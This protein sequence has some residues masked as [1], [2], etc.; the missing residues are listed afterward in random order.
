MLAKIRFKYRVAARK[1]RFIIYL[2]RKQARPSEPEVVLQAAGKVDLSAERRSAQTLADLKSFGEDLASFH[3]DCDVRARGRR[4][5]DEFKENAL[6]VE[7]VYQKFRQASL[8]SEYLPPG[9]NWLLDNYHVVQSQINDIKRHFP[10]GYER[11]LPKLVK[12]SLSGLPRSYELSLK[13]LSLTEAVIDKE[14]LSSFIDGYQSAIKLKLG[15]LWSVPIMLK[16]ALVATLSGLV[17]SMAERNEKRKVVVGVLEKIFSDKESA[18]SATKI[19]SSFIRNFEEYEE[20]FLE[21]NNYLLNRLR[22]G[23]RLTG[24]ALQWFEENL[25]ERRV[26]LIDLPREEQ[27][28]LAR[29]QLIIGNAIQSLRSSSLVDWKAWVESHSSID[30]VFSGDLEDFYLKSDFY[31]RDQCRKVVESLS[32]LSGKTEEAVALEVLNLARAAQAESFQS[33]ESDRSVRQKKREHIGYYLIG[34]GYEQLLKALGLDSSLKIRIWSFF[35]KNVFAIYFGSLIFFSLLFWLVLLA[36][37]YRLT[38]N[39]QL[40]IVVSLLGVLPLSQIATH[41]VQWIATKIVPAKSLPKLEFAQGITSEYKTLVVVHGMLVNKEQIKKI[42]EDLEVRYL[43]NVEINAGFALLLDPQDHKAA[44]RE[45]DAELIE[46]TEFLLKELKARQASDNFYFLTRKREYNPKEGKFIARERKRGKLEELLN[47]I[48]GDGPDSFVISESERRK[49]KEYV[50]VLTL[51][52]DSQLPRGTLRKLAGALAH[53]L[54]RPEYDPLANRVTAGYGYLNPRVEFDLL[55]ANATKFAKLFSCYSGLDPYTHIVSEV[56]Q[57][58]FG[59][60]S[61]FGKGILDVAAFHQSLKG[62]VPE[63]A[64]LSH[65]LFE[66]CYARSGLVSDV[67]IYDDFPSRYQVQARREHRWIRGDWQLL[68]WLGRRVPTTGGAKIKNP[69]SGLSLLKIADNL[70]RSLVPPLLFFW[71]VTFW[72]VGGIFSLAWILIALFVFAFPLS[73]HFLQVFSMP[74]KNVLYREHLRALLKSFKTTIFQAVVNFCFLPFAAFNALSAIITTLYRLFV[75]KR[76]LLEWETALTTEMKLGSSLKV[77]T[78]AL[79]GGLLMTAIALFVLIF[80]VGKQVLALAPALIIWFLSPLA[81]YSLNQKTEFKPDGVLTREQKDYLLQIARETWSFFEENLT[82]H[83]HYLIPDNIQF[84]PDERIAERTSAS[85]IGLSLMAVLAAS[86]FGFISKAEAIEKLHLII[87]TLKRL[88]KFHG[89]FF[90]W[91]GT[92]DPRPL[93][94]RYVSTVDSANLAAALISVKSACLQLADEFMIEERLQQVDHLDNPKKSIL[95]I[96]AREIAVTCERLVDQMDFAYLYDH[97][98]NIFRIGYDVDSA[99]NDQSYYDLLASEARIASLIAIALGQ[100]PTKHWFALGRPLVNTSEGTCLISWAGTMFEYLMPLLWTYDY[101]GT[102]L[103]ESHKTAVRSQI[104]YARLVG[105]PW[106]ISESG[107]AG[108]DFE[109]SYQYKAFGVPTIGLK[110]GLDEDLVVSS[111]SSFLALAIAPQETLENLKVL[112]EKYQARARYGFIEAIDF[113][114]ERLASDEKFHPVKSYLAHH[115]GMI[116]ASLA[117]FFHDKVF[118]RRFHADKTIRAVELLLQEKFPDRVSIISPFGAD[119]KLERL[120]T[121]E[122]DEDKQRII[123]TPHTKTPITHIL[124]NGNYSVM[125]DNAG[126]GYSK[127][128]EEILINWW[129][130]DPEFNQL[131]QHFYLRDLKAREIWSIGYQPNLKKPDQYTVFFSADKA[132]I[133]RRDHEILSHLE[134]I[135]APEDDLE[136]R[137]IQIANLSEKQRILDITSYFE[138]ALTSAKAFAAHPAFQKLFIQTFFDP[139]LDALFVVKKPKS[140]EEK[141]L[142]LFH[143]VVSKVVW[144]PVQFD[145]SR[146]SFIGRESGYQ[147]PRALNFDLNLTGSQ[148]AVLEPCA[149]LRVK[150]EL[151][152]GQSEKIYFITGIAQDLDEARAL[153]QKYK[154]LHQLNRAFELAWSQASIELKT[155]GVNHVDAF[156]FQRLANFILFKRTLGAV[157]KELISQNTLAQNAFWRFGVS[158]DYPIILLRINSPTDIKLLSKLLAAHFYLRSRGVRFDLVILNEYGVSYL[159]N[160]NEEAAFTIRSSMSGSLVE[161]PGGIYLRSSQQISEEEKILLSSTARLTFSGVNGE[162]EDQLNKLILSSEEK[163]KLEESALNRDLFND[164]RLPP[165]AEIASSGFAGEDF[166]IELINMAEKTTFTPLPWSNVVAEPEFGFLV[167]ESGGGFTWGINSREGRLTPW[168]NDPLLDLPSEVFYLKSNNDIWSATPKPA[169]KG[170]YQ[171]RHGFCGSSFIC[172]NPDKFRSKL[173]VELG[174][175]GYKFYSLEINNLT[176]SRQEVDLFFALESILGVDNHQINQLVIGALLSKSNLLYFKNLYTNDKNGSFLGVWADRQLMYGTLCRSKFYGRDGVRS[177]PALLL[178]KDL[179]PFSDSENIS[180]FAAVGL[181]LA[182][183]AGAS[184]RLSF[185]IYSADTLESVFAKAEKLKGAFK[186]IRMPVVNFQ[187]TR[188]ELLSAIKVETPDRDF[189]SLVN[190]WLAHQILSCRLY[191]RSGFYQSGGAIGFRDQLQDAIGLL[192]FDPKILKK[193][194]LLHASRQFEEG[195]VQHWWHPPS[196]RGVRTRISDDFL[197]LPYA[198]FR[199]IRATGDLDILNETAGYL[200]GDLLRDDQHEAFVNV[201]RS[202]KEEAIYQH[203]ALAIERAFNFGERGL[204]LIGCGDWNDGMNRVGEAGRGESVWLGFFLAGILKDLIPIA[205]EPERRQRWQNVLTSLKDALEKNAWDGDWYLRAFFDDGSPLGSAANEECRIDSLSQSWSLLSGVGDPERARKAVLSAYQILFDREARI[206]KL[207]DPPFV[208]ARP[209]PG[210]IGSYIPGIRENGA[211]YTHAACWLILALLRLGEVDKAYELFAALNPIA[212]GRDLE[213]IKRYQTEPYVLCGDVY[214]HPQHLGRG[215]WSWYTGSAGWFLQVALSGILGINFENGKLVVN[216]SLPASWNGYRA[217]LRLADRGSWKI[218]VLG[219][220][221]TIDTL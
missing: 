176:A 23:G 103:S 9:A 167:T 169:G 131:G 203:L 204:P 16:L 221:V 52:T 181:S 200:K 34:D 126:S 44:E 76:N 202:G 216:P 192:L 142:I 177:R 170:R 89:H 97:E 174:E 124:S 94:P 6:I 205:R 37:T 194:I 197:W 109:K 123:D 171:V 178:S 104:A 73:T 212:K 86:D 210:F 147:F 122:I 87:N 95:S 57:D 164:Q 121:S 80:L 135:V 93:S 146:F 75:S 49:L 83:R 51:D 128:G 161:K 165:P 24:L 96:K 207:L 12:G 125:I 106:G 162:F 217:E 4:L 55:S 36:H 13:F 48:T 46:Y 67:V 107:Y 61:S 155:G 117:N 187:K 58:L 50:F 118:C 5:I 14:L 115:Q 213:W 186:Q 191:G 64:V 133:K 201:E 92:I 208:K 25:R 132:E 158:G 101:V 18:N 113:T 188:G 78:K 179:H 22:E 111:Y 206:V 145:S 8:R 59:E 215:G 85:N 134:L 88:E 199:Y 157:E 63:N 30:R 102:L 110:R 90:N 139:E 120:E 114:P 71:M 29:E 35:K 195:D 77:V 84:F 148:G 143:T 189:N 116:L 28:R 54:N 21:N 156:L 3:F 7:E 79:R 41:L 183:K 26:A 136:I 190:G 175:G 62:K 193:Q 81:A 137:R 38:T 10:K 119:G 53:P 91:Y 168:S 42:F 17:S 108:V 182:L 154:S 70:R 130:S 166:Q 196:G 211:Q 99:R 47:L 31:T 33:L 45:G 72:C 129:H 2:K 220:K 159:Q 15:E 214:S 173:S 180:N 151:E 127:H 100:V 105:I 112:E 20:E 39:W 11:S 1:L 185:V 209:Y 60:G 66:G 43:G 144:E 69:F 219:D 172:E 56:Y 152:A 218:T 141:E 150:L 184:E 98:R 32:R 82:T 163:E 74:P 140:S 160:L 27:S 149:S 153:C 138:P 68:P 40:A 65:D 198:V 19:L